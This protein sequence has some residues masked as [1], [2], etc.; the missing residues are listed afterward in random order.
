[1]KQPARRPRV[2]T[3]TLKNEILERIIE[4]Q[5]ISG[6]ASDRNMPE[7]RIIYRTLAT[8][9]AFR[10]QFE[11]AK[12]VQLYRFEEILLDMAGSH[13]C[14]PRELERFLNVTQHLIAR[15]TPRS[16]RLDGPLQDLACRYLVDPRSK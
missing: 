1:M 6:I 2:L 11:A 13:E 8:D 9:D 16:Q 12:I 5:A 3:A 15:R 10:R 4:G 14:D 7:E